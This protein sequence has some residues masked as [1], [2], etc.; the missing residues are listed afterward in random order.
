MCFNV[1]FRLLKTIYMCICWC[2]TEMKP[3]VFINITCVVAHYN[4]QNATHHVYGLINDMLHQ[5]VSF[6]YKTIFYVTTKLCL[7]AMQPTTERTSGSVTPTLLKTTQ[8]DGQPHDL[9]RQP[10]HV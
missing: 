6:P 3:S 5:Q 2:V 8:P 7:L 9:T 4:L 10:V 1:N